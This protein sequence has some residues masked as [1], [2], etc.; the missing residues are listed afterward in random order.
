MVAKKLKTALV[1]KGDASNYW[2][3]SRELFESMRNNLVLEN[4]NAAVIDGVHAVISANDALTIAAIGKRSSSDHHLDAAEL[5]KHSISP[6]LKPDVTRLRRILHI[7]SHVEYGPSL[8][9][10]KE[11]ERVSQDVERFLGWAEGVFQKFGS[12]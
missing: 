10:S 2:K 11:A 5:L 3:R 12:K 4:W 7:K 6:D 1:F 9:S 8:V